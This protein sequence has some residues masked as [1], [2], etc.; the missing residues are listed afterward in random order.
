MSINTANVA[1]QPS[2]ACSEVAPLAF[3][4]VGGRGRSWFVVCEDFKYWENGERL[5]SNM[6]REEVEAKEVISAY[7]PK[8]PVLP[9][10][11]LQLHLSRS[12]K[13]P[14]TRRLCWTQRLTTY[15]KAQVRWSL[16][17][18]Q[19][20]GKHTTQ[21]ETLEWS[22]VRRRPNQRREITHTYIPRLFIFTQSSPSFPC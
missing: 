7:F 4:I 3:V 22:H 10:L 14:H 20:E 11:S 15:T 8:R 12:T 6:R 21:N 18:K 1:S 19:Y 5:C 16:K 9:C 17:L 13:P 2:L